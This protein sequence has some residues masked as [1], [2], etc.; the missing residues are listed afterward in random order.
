MGSEFR[1][2][3]PWLPLHT[4]CTSRLQWSK[5]QFEG[6]PRGGPKVYINHHNSRQ[7]CQSLGT[8]IQELV[9][10]KFLEHAWLVRFLAGLLKSN[11]VG[12]KVVTKGSSNR[13]KHDSIQLLLPSIVF[14]QLG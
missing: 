6:V 2:P 9:N 3:P 14:Q 7:Y 10:Q 13:G 1:F 4:M 8:L 12:V 11:L 5:L